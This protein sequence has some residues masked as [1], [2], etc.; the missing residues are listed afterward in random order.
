VSVTLAGKGIFSGS[1]G[2]RG[3]GGGSDIVCQRPFNFKVFP[4]VDHIELTATPDTICSYED[5]ELR[6]VVIDILARK[7][8][9]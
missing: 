9:F 7:L 8:R 3:S 6:A 4:P 1:D 2:S 5:A